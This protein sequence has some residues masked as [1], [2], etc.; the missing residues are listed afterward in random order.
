ME[1]CFCL[2]STR[3]IP[4]AKY[5]QNQHVDSI[6]LFSAAIAYSDFAGAIAYNDPPVPIIFRV[7]KE[8]ISTSGTKI[9]SGAIVALGLGAANRDPQKFDLPD[10]FDITR[11]NNE[12][13]GFSKGIHFCLGAV[14][15]RME[16][17]I[18]FE[19]LLTRMPDISF[20]FNNLPVP[21]RDRPILE[22]PG[23]VQT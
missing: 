5:P 12:H 9:P 20:D 8:D 17:T 11:T 2:F 3:S 13:L 18:C 23:F 1:L 7:A 14:L 16:L 15:A 4:L 21:K 19:T 10:V 22:L 6:S